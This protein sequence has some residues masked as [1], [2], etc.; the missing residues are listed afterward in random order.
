MGGRTGQPI[1]LNTLTVAGVCSEISSVQY[2][3]VPLYIS[4]PFVQVDSSLPSLPSYT[5]HVNPDLSSDIFP[6]EEAW[7]AV[8]AWLPEWVTCESPECVFRASQDGYKSVHPPPTF[9]L[10][11]TLSLCSCFLVATYCYICG[12]G[13]G[14]QNEFQAN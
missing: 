8:W 6:N 11:F 12:C 1:I 13:L 4:L 5:R 7:Q 2:S 14:M 9:L 3:E 10:H